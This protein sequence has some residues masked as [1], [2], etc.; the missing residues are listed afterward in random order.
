MPVWL[1]RYRAY[2][3]VLVPWASTRGV[4]RALGGAF[5]CLCLCVYLIHVSCS[6]IRMPILI[7][8]FLSQVD[9][10]GFAFPPPAADWKVIPF[11]SPGSPAHVGMD[12][13]QLQLGPPGL[14]RRQLQRDGYSVH[15]CMGQSRVASFIS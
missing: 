1:L 13:R 14:G 11:S 7:M 3:C 10:L 15:H 8:A 4:T 12:S 6:G 2:R 5:V 9:L